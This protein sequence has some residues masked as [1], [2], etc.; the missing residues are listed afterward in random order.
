LQ[1]WLIEEEEEEEEMVVVFSPLR[2]PCRFLFFQVNTDNRE[3]EECE[4]K[5]R[6]R[7]PELQYLVDAD[8][9]KIKSKQRPRSSRF[10]HVL[11]EQLRGS[12]TRTSEKKKKLIN[13]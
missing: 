6:G 7:W 4:E 3:E 2:L 12:R 5:D 11:T 1:W 8:D 10:P 13:L 9:P